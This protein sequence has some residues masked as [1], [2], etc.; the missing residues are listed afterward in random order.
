MSNGAHALTEAD[1]A[2]IRQ[3]WEA[4]QEAN[5][6]ADWDAAEPLLTD[7]YVQ[8]DPRVTGPIRG[9]TAWREWADSLDFQELDGGFTME[10]LSGSGDVACAVWGFDGRWQ[11]G[12]QE[13]VAVGKGLAVFQ[14]GTDGSWRM[15]RNAWNMDP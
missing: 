13:M 10:G 15:S 12:G 8:L 5:F 3:V 14:R 1:L 9:R 11:E 6:A 7:D 4:I 2:A